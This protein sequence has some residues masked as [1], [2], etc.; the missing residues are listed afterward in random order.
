[1]T[2]GGGT[3]EEDARARMTRKYARMLELRQTRSETPPTRALREL[4]REFPGALRELDAAPLA[5]LRARAEDLER[6]V[7]A[8]WITAT[9]RYHALMRGALHAKRC[10]SALGGALDRDAFERAAR[11]TPD[12]LAWVDD[13]ATLAAPPRGRLVPVVVARVARELGISEE[14]ARELALGG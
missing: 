14:R 13:L 1:M 7:A 3:G 8:P 4:A 6:G 11:D 5:A 2:A 12:A 9:D 10:L